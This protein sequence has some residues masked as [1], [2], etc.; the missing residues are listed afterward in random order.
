MRVRAATF[1][2]LRKLSFFFM[3]AWREAGPGALGFTGASDEVMRE[4][5]TEESLKAKLTNPDLKIFVAEE[6]G[7]ILGFASLKKIDSGVA[8]LSGIVVLQSL[9]GRG[10]GTELFKVVRE[11]AVAESY[12][13]IVVKTELFNEMAIAFYKKLGFVE[14]K[15]TI[16]HIE[17]T[18]VKLMVLERSLLRDQP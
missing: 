6:A 11:F 10:V 18:E 3:E 2:D 7:R 17:G 9:V 1:D 15:E 13:K 4:L 8:E 14:S 16:E 12:H 5:S